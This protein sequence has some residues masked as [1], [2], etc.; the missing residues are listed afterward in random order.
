MRRLNALVLWMF[1]AVVLHAFWLGADAA[2]PVWDGAPAS[3]LAA[4]DRQEDEIAYRYTF[5]FNNL[6]SLTPDF[7]AAKAEMESLRLLNAASEEALR[8]LHPEGL[9]GARLD[10]FEAARRGYLLACARMEQMTRQAASYLENGAL[11]REENQRLTELRHQYVQSLK[12]A[13]A[14]FRAV[15]A[16]DV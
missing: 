2:H 4:C 15:G 3:R 10:H 12:Q 11:T 9:Q 5:I 1:V 16:I 7:S 13:K 8:A 6:K 14:A